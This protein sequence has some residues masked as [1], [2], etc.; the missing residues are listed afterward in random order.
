MSQVKGVLKDKS[1]IVVGNNVFVK[2]EIS[3][4]ELNLS[5]ISEVAILDLQKC[6]EKVSNVYH[7]QV[8]IKQRVYLVLNALAKEIH[9][10]HRLMSVHEINENIHKKL[11]TSYTCKK[12]DIIYC[13]MIIAHE[14]SCTQKAR[15]NLLNKEKSYF[16][17]LRLFLDKK[18]YRQVYLA[19]ELYEDFI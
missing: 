12:P 9:K 16:E 11:L 2:R 15:F 4:N 13:M 7:K 5:R 3:R 14:D 10:V 18:C 17:D 1:L 8:F 19:I 6:L